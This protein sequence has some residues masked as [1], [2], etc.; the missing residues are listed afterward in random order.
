MK[1]ESEMYNK[2]RKKLLKVYNRDTVADVTEEMDKLS[3]VL[4]KEALARCIDDDSS[5]R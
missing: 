5:L 1:I 4:K 2:K 3:M